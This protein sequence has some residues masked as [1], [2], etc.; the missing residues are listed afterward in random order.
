VTLMQSTHLPAHTYYSNMADR[1]ARDPVV[2]YQGRA[3]VPMGRGFSLWQRMNPDA[4]LV[5]ID[6]MEGRPRAL[7]P[8]QYRV[9]ELAIKCIDG[10]M[11]TMR[12]MAVR[13]GMAAST[14]SRTLAKLQAWGI[15]AVIVGRGRWAGLVIMHRAKAD[16]LDR[17]RVAA[18][19]RVRR[20]SE[21]AQRRLSRLQANVASY[22]LEKERG[23]DSL[24]YYL[25][26]TDTYMGAT[27]TAQLSVPWTA[28]DVAGV[29]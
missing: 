7:T 15:L 2:E 20:W 9:L 1:L 16:G 19:A 3:T 18:K 13:L 8:K 29:R 25:L 10:E 5:W 27:L 17:F 4:H 11:L 28:E 22:L 23:V 12:Q 6:D 14:I 26:S 24:Y 21:A